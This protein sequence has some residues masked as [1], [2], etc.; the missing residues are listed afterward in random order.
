MSTLLDSLLIEIG[1]DP[2]KYTT[3]RKEIE[4]D[5]DKTK[6]RAQRTAKDIE[7]FGKKGSE[8]FSKMKKEA[9]ELFAAFLGARGLKDLIVNTTQ[10]E[11]STG[12]FAKTLG[13]SVEELSRWRNAAILAGGS[14]EGMDQSMNGLRQ[15]FEQFART[16]QSDVIQYFRALKIAV[17]DAKGNLRPLGDILLDLADKFSKMPAPEAKWFGKAIGLDEGTINLLIKGREEVK[18]Y[19]DEASRVGTISDEQSKAAIRLQESW[20]RLAQAGQTYG[21]WITEGLSGPLSDVFDW[22]T[23]LSE[24]AIPWLNDKKMP[25]W[26]PSELW[27]KYVNPPAPTYKEFKEQQE[28]STAPKPLSRDEQAEY[29]K[30]AAIKRGIDPNIALQ[31]ARGEGLYKYTGDF[32][33]SFGP[34]QLHYGGIAMGGNAG[35]GLGDIFTKQTGLNAKDPMTMKQQIDFALDYALQ[36]GWGSWHGFHGLPTSGLPDS[37]GA[38]GALSMSDHR[39]NTSTSETHIGEINVNTQATD[40]NGIARDIYGALER[41]SLASQAN[42]GPQ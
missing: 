17:V 5:F 33:S 39:S 34:Y 42:T 38:F 31:V 8:F 1:L 36:H 2:S 10:M 37:A 13:T 24:K 14:A 6:E 32:G 27:H 18:K 23:K 11:A 12:R 15:N 19:L 7:L 22:L 9:L 40:A 41:N 35:P 29:I 21:R 30:Q 20:R 26:A 16:G 28:Q 4:K 3:G 25:W